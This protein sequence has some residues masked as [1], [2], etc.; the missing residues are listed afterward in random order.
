MDGGRIPRRG[1]AG[2]GGERGERER[3]RE[4]EIERDEWSCAICE[5]FPEFISTDRKSASYLRFPLDFRVSSGANGTAKCRL[6]V[7]L[8]GFPGG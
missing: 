7:S 5:E 3:E 2:T 1:P 4:R 8:C 6:S